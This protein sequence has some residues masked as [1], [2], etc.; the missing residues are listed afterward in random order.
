MYKQNEFSSITNFF[1]SKNLYKK[2]ILKYILLFI[3]YI[4]YILTI[5]FI[6]INTFR[7][8]NKGNNVLEGVSKYWHIANLV[9]LIVNA[10]CILIAFIFLIYYQDND[11]L[12]LISLC[13]AFYLG[14]RWGIIFYITL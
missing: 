14:L 1:Y 11:L 5:T 6:V 13:I 8:D 4:E 3:T 12:P 2:W 7:A 9:S 10:L